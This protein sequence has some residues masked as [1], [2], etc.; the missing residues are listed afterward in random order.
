MSKSKILSL[1]CETENISQE[2]IQNNI[3][4]F[5]FQNMEYKCVAKIFTYLE[6][7]DYH[8]LNDEHMLFV[9]NLFHKYRIDEYY[10]KLIN[11]YRKTILLRAKNID[12]LGK[13]IKKINNVNIINDI[14]FGID[15]N[16]LAQGI[17]GY[18]IGYSNVLTISDFIYS[19][20]LFEY[21]INEKYSGNFNIETLVLANNID[22]I[23]YIMQNMKPELNDL[24]IAIKQNISYY[25]GRYN[26]KKLLLWSKENKCFMN[27]SI[28]GAIISGSLDICKWLCD[29]L[30]NIKSNTYEYQQI[31]AE[32]G[33]I[34]ILE[35]ILVEKQM[36]PYNDLCTCAA[37]G[38]HLATII[39]LKNNNF[40]KIGISMVITA[41]ENG[42]YDIVK[43]A[44]EGPN[45]CEWQTPA[46]NKVAL[47]AAKAGNI[48]ILEYLYKKRC[49]MHPEYIS[50][51]AEF[52]NI[53]TIKWLLYNKCPYDDSA[54]V[55][56]AMGGYY[57]VLELLYN[58]GCN[59]TS[60]VCIV[61]AKNGNLD[62]LK[63]VY[64]K[65]CKFGYTVL[66]T[67]MMYNQFH[68]YDWI[69]REIGLQ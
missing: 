18:S 52:G 67:S 28:L 61:C 25:A 47:L 58:S 31:A 11:E 64:N 38:G 14:V 50:I 30:L 62:M 7:N 42:F 68:V 21:C 46:P 19:V 35:W 66:Y 49:E 39:W 59:L 53:E 6:N 40:S 45:N 9:M 41:A 32:Y 2:W 16:E 56:A 10:N 17:L 51:A 54:C 13:E 3:D 22:V 69:K 44:I 8:L 36:K 63:Y 24:K 33:H 34:N 43:W 57:D 15:K 20:E 60:K 27:T 5:D 26:N 4:I 48:Q 65:G 12:H 1:M 29:E 55:S 23:D 37:K